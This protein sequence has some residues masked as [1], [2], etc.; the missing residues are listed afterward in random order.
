MVDY[1]AEVEY[2]FNPESIKV[3]DSLLKDEQTKETYSLA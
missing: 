3:P 2:N 1:N